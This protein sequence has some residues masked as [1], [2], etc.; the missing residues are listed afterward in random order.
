MNPLASFCPNPPDY[1]LDW[2]ALEASFDWIRALRGCPQDAVFHAEGD[3]STHVRMV[4]S[5][6]AAMPEWRSLPDSEREILFA[7]ALLHDVAKP[8]CTREES[9]RITSRGHSA[10]GAIDA[11]AILWELGAGFKERER[12]CALVRCHQAPFHLIDRDDAQPRAFLISQTARCDL[13]ALLAKA[14]ILGRVCQD[15]AQLLLRVSLFEEFCDEQ[16]CLRQPRAFPSA[17]S[18]FEYFRNPGRD[19]NY[20]AHE[21]FR[22]QATLLSGLPGAGKD[23]WI[24]RHLP[25]QPV[26]SLDAIRDELDESAT[27]KQ[28]K[29][30]QEARERARELLRA[31][32]DFTW[33][34]TNLSSDRRR[35]LVDLFTAYGARVRIVYVEAA[36]TTLHR[37]NRDRSAPVPTSAI[38]AM[39]RRW[40]IPTPVEAQEVQYHIG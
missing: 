2:D 21:D 31:H 28:G 16:A 6:M 24:R 38:A 13:L 27:G 18:R 33:N 32:R 25:E 39:M 1:R 29:V 22:C 15:Q 14:D 10:R 8:S 30:I 40:E 36:K 12:I 26:V 9:G 37:Q 23:T 5:A 20:L 7:A 3:V 17:H 11:R 4:C 19:P 34:A 35:Q